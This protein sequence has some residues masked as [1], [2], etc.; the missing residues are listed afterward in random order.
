K[1]EPNDPVSRIYYREAS[2]GAERVLIDPTAFS[3]GARA[4]DIDYWSVSPNARYLAYGV[5]LGGAEVG[6]LRI[7]SAET[8]ADLPETIDRTASATPSWLADTSFLYPRL[9][10]P[11]PGGTQ[12]LSGG[13]IFLHVLGT[14]PAS[15]TEVFAPGRVPGH[16]VEAEYFFRAYVSPD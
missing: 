5:S 2:G 9:P 11:P 13:H 10:A 3:V 14:D 7:R 4:A 6:I 1:A 8:G 12:V 16:D 15:D